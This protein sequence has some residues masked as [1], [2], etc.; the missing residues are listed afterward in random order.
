VQSV[1]FC[2]NFRKSFFL[3]MFFFQSLWVFSTFWLYIDEVKEK[4][5]CSTEQSLRHSFPLE[6][7]EKAVAQW[8]VKKLTFHFCLLVTSH[9]SAYFIRVFSLTL[10]Q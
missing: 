4:I 8:F 5:R 2:W 3:F 6:K 7:Q 10:N 9:Y 1:S